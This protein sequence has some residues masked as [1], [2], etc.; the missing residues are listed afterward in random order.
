M[1]W[2]FIILMAFAILHKVLSPSFRN[3]SFIC[4]QIIDGSMLNWLKLHPH[5]KEMVGHNFLQIANLPHPSIQPHSQLIFPNELPRIAL[6]FSWLVVFYELVL[7]V[8][9]TK[10]RNSRLFFVM[11]FCFV[12]A[13][14]LIRPEMVF[15][16]VLCL[17]LYWMQPQVKR[18]KTII[19]LM[20]LLIMMTFVGRLW[21]T[22]N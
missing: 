18:R 15:A 20:C 11:S 7:L 2:I 16:T 10:W 3:G 1:G 19:W 14:P 21:N 8:L 22:I 5:W 9:A 17:L 13:I 12:A 6:A 4:L